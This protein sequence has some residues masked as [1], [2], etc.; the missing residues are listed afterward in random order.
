MPYDSYEAWGHDVDRLPTLTSAAYPLH[1]GLVASSELWWSSAIV[2]LTLKDRAVQEIRLYPVE[3]GRDVTPEARV[4]RPTGHGPHTLTEGRPVL[5]DREN[6]DRILQR[7]TKLSAEYGTAIDVD[8]G[9]GI[10]RL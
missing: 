6:G 5:A 7:L 1:P 2:S 10:I 4:R 8:D 9:V 3:M